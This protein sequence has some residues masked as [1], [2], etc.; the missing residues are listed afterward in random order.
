MKKIVFLLLLMC[1]SFSIA[2]AQIIITNKFE[3]TEDVAT[4][5][6]AYSYLKKQHTYFLTLNSS[7][8]FD[9]IFIIELGETKEECINTT[10]SLIQ[11]L[12]ELEN[13]ESV[14]I[15][16]RNNE[17]FFSKELMLGAPYY[18][19]ISADH[20]YAGSCNIT[21]KELEK[22]IKKLDK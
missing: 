8:Q 1:C 13:G 5:R 16:N 21:K 7:N 2:T 3:K 12:N 11:L 17:Y 9:D 15:S 20:K 6:H 19:I 14:K 10:Q 4:I 18:L 22:I